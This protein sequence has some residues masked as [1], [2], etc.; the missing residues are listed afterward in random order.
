MSELASVDVAR[1]HRG[2]LKVIHD[3][4]PEERVDLLALVIG[5]TLD[6][7]NRRSR[8]LPE[9]PPETNGNHRALSFEERAGLRILIDRAVR[10]QLRLDES[11][12]HCRECGLWVELGFTDGCDACARQR[13]RS[14]G[15]AGSLARTPSRGRGCYVLTR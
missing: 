4:K 10:E 12:R 11:T 15:E 3:L 13:T 5:G 7:P 2:A 8:E 9:T 14:P 1:R 6:W